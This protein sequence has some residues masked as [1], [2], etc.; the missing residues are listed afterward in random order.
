VFAVNFVLL[1]NHLANPDMKKIL[2]VLVSVLALSVSAREFKDVIS[3]QAAQV[4]RVDNE[5]LA[6]ELPRFIFS[7]T[8]TKI[9]IR[10]KNPMH[11]KL[12]SNGYKLPFIVNGTDQLVQFDQAGV[13]SIACTFTNDN[14]LTLLFENA[15]FSQE[16]PVISIWYM[17]L[18]IVVLL[19]VIGYKLAFSR[20]KLTVITSTE[21]VE[22]EQKRE[23]YARA[24]SNM[25][26][27]KSEE[28]VLV[29]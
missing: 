20:K 7:H 2:L 28:E 22:A 4:N 3:A 14:K 17:V 12:V 8:N 15:S 26:V 9:N 5:D 18:P 11:D 10:F 1:K 13:G 27:V 24:T 21:V 16:V 23:V 19:L 25:K 6:I 29:P